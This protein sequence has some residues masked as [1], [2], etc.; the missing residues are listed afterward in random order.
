MDVRDLR[1]MPDD[2]LRRLVS[3]LRRMLFP[4]PAVPT[5]EHQDAVYVAASARLEIAR[6]SSETR[7]AGLRR[8][9]NLIK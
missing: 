7:L 5:R 8:W 1:L 9:D 2:E 4:Q 3:A 6:R